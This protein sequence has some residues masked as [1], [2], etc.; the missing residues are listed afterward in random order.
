MENQKHNIERSQCCCFTGHRI[1]EKPRYEQIS[2]E[3]SQ[4]IEALEVKGVTHYY[5]GGAVG[6][7]LIAA[8]TIANIK[9]L[10]PQITL[11]LALPYPGYNNGWRKADTEIFKKVMQRADEIVYISDEYYGGCMLARD[12]F[13]VD[14]CGTCICYLE[15]AIGGTAYTVNYAI[16]KDLDIINVASHFD[17]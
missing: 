10:V 4:T 3:L 16:K 1:I 6:F 17:I 15:K 13:M 7:D 9:M 12:R 8:V 2:S 11:T 14:K 5:A